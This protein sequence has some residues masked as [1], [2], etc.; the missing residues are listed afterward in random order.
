MKHKPYTII[1]K[2]TGISISHV[3]RVLRRKRKPSLR[4]L[5][6]LATEMEIPIDKLIKKLGLH[7]VNK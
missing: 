2:H 1:A 3:S 5:L 6:L 4:V 7:G